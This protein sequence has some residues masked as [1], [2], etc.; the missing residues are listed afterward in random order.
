MAD[1]S[2]AD[3]LTLIREQ[4][5][6]EIWQAAVQFSAALQSFRKVDMGTKI[7]RYPVI[8]ALPSA[9]FLEG[10]DADDADSAKPTT[11]MTWTD[12]TLTAEELGGIV[13]IPENVIDDAASDFDLWAEIRPRI[14]EAVGAAVDA[15]VFFGTNAPAS[16]PIGLVPAAVAAGNVVAEGASG[17]DLAEDINMTIGKVEDDGYDATDAYGRRSLRRRLRGLRDDNNQPIFM[18]TI[19]E[20][21][22]NVNSIYNAELHYVR[23]GSWDSG[24]ATIL[25][26]DARFAILGIRQDLTFKMLDQ[27]AVTINGTLVSLAEHDLLGLRFKMRLGFQTAQT[28]TLEGGASAYPFAVLNGGPSGS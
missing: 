2:R 1:I 3:A 6:A 13:V 10:E 5:G 15:A 22:V 8:G 27:A 14:A 20:L 16:W 26:G 7:S 4:N 24:E 25:V 21:G 11:A 12:R 28:A 17:V 18:S 19:N 9:S 23:N